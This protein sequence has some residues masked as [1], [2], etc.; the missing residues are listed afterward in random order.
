MITLETKQ[1][2]ISVE[3]RNDRLVMS[4]TPSQDGGPD[5]A[6][7]MTSMTGNDAEKLS[8]ILSRMSEYARE[9]DEVNA[10]HAKAFAQVIEFIDLCGNK[11]I[12]N[13][14]RARDLPPR[15]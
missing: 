1:A 2:R 15:V 4:V 3:Y 12:N 5:M 14:D 11:P 10:K 9:L 8:L 7:F 6:T 13:T